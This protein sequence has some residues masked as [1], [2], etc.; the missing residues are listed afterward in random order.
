[1]S[2]RDRQAQT[3]ERGTGCKETCIQEGRKRSAERHIHTQA[4]REKE[5]EEVTGL[6]LS[7]A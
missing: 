3:E 2:P 1:M 6:L 4:E 7:L 5:R